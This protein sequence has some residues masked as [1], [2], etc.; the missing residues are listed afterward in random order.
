M[1]LKAYTITRLVKT[2]AIHLVH[3]ASREEAIE[4]D[5]Q[6]A[7]IDSWAE[8]IYVGAPRVRRAPEDDPE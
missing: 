1:K 3:A 5:N 2:E 8:D 4:R 7:P 6:E